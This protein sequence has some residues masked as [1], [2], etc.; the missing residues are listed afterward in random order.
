M[1]KGTGL[2]LSTV[3][4]IVKQSGGYIEVYSKPGFGSTFKVFLA[5]AEESPPTARTGS[6]IELDPRGTE[7]VLLVEDEAVVRDLV[8]RVLA[9]LGYTVLQAAEAEQALELGRKLQGPLHLLVSDVVLPGIN[10]CEL[11]RQLRLLRSELRALYIS[12]YTSS[13]IIQ[14]GIL[15]PGVPFLQKPFSPE[16]LARKVREVLD[17]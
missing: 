10:G 1:G 12:G 11:G 4:G 17:A 5:R 3:Y 8:R 6:L 2:G 13:A 15:E 14:R 16:T 7:T 9:G